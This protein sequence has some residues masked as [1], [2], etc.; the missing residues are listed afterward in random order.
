MQELDQPQMGGE[1][2]VTLALF[3]AASQ[4]PV[5]RHDP[6]CPGDQFANSLTLVNKLVAASVRDA[7]HFNTSGPKVLASGAALTKIATAVTESFAWLG[8]CLQS[9][10]SG[11]QPGGKKK[12]HGQPGL[13][14][15]EMHVLGVLHEATTSFCSQL[16]VCKS[17]AIGQID[18][19]QDKAAE[20]LLAVV[21]VDNPSPAPGCILGTLTTGLKSSVPETWQQKTIFE[22]IVGSQRATL[23]GIRDRCNARLQLMKSIK[24]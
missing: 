3:W 7:M 17:W 22:D 4:L 23:V 19:L 11:L 20:S 13:E 15:P 10:V 6:S 2:L 14:T 12:K 16:E 1:E 24:F 8:L 5:Q 18:T 9:W 21:D